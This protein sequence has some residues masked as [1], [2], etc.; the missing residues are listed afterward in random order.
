LLTIGS[1]FLQELKIDFTGINTSTSQ[2]TFSRLNMNN[3]VIEKEDT[4][5]YYLVD[6]SSEGPILGTF[7]SQKLT[8]KD[9]SAHLMTCGAN[10]FENKKIEFPDPYDCINRGR[11]GCLFSHSTKQTMDAFKKRLAD[12]YGSAFVRHARALFVKQV[13]NA[14][15][16]DDCTSNDVF[17]AFLSKD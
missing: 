6:I 17:L 14:L 4:C 11:K 5:D 16:K 9:S 10:H 15:K 12:V 1:N 3:L 7:S 13:F 8:A 2:L